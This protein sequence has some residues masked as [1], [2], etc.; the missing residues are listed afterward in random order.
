MGG[1]LPNTP[2]RQF[3]RQ[4]PQQNLTLSEPSKNSR[5][6]WVSS[7]GERSE[8]TATATTVTMLNIVTKFMR[9]LCEKR[10]ENGVTRGAVIESMTAAIDAMT[11]SACASAPIRPVYNRCALEDG[12]LGI[13]KRTNQGN[14]YVENDASHLHTRQKRDHQAERVCPQAD[15]E[16]II[17]QRVK[18]QRD[19]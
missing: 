12:S 7:K 2:V 5:R 15:D 6:W 17:H 3:Q 9:T 18:R 1:N 13:K 4:K 8:N 10:Q 16:T 14:E 11:C 19:E